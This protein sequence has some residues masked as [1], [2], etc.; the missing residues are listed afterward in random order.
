MQRFY[1]WKRLS[2]ETEYKCDFDLQSVFSGRFTAS[3]VYSEDEDAC[4]IKAEYKISDQYNDYWMCRK[5]VHC[6]F[7]TVA[8]DLMVAEES[9]QKRKYKKRRTTK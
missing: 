1:R 7:P 3:S 5:H 2:K 8:K 4:N 6:L 9:R